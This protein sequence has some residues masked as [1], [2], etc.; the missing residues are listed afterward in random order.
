MAE[1]KVT[2][3]SILTTDEGQ[4]M[5]DE[6]YAGTIENIQKRLVSASIKNQELSG[7]PV[8]GAF[9]VKRFANAQSQEYGTARK[10]GAGN[11]VKEKSVKVL[12]D[13]DRE[14]VEEIEEKDVRL[15][16]VKDLVVRRSNNHGTRMIAELDREF[17][18]VGAENA[19][20][21][22]VDK[23][24]DIA[25]QLET[26]IQECENTENQF[27]DGVERELMSLVLNTEMYGKVRNELDK[28]PRSNVD[29]SQGEFYAWHEVE[30]QSSTRLPKGVSAILMVKGAIA[31]PV[32]ANGYA[33]EKINLSEAYGIELFWHYGTKVITPDLI[34]VI[35]DEA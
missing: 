11:K 28:M 25:D 3:L 16:P 15:H 1:E 20:V 7:D 22:T 8:V 18:K 9:E 6:A 19:V 5:L 10:N 29:T 30:T 24:A 21:V 26:L 33:A 13:T 31:Q 17:F 35:K 12:V 34:F 14:Y 4:A 32:M 2:A 23:T 27:V